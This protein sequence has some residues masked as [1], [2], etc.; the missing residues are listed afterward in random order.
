MRWIR[1]YDDV[2]AAAGEPCDAQEDPVVALL[3][4]TVARH[5]R[6]APDIGL[7]QSRTPRPGRHRQ[8]AA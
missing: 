2:A 6:Q 1:D 5:R 8:A 3:A 4:A 7:E